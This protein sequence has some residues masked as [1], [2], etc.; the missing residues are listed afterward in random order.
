MA[1]VLA[2]ITPLV[3]DRLWRNRH[4][5]RLAHQLPEML[6]QWAMALQGGLSAEGALREVAR[7]RDD[8]IGREVRRVLLARG[9]RLGTLSSC[10][11]SRSESL[12]SASLAE[13]GATI[14]AVEKTGAPMAALLESLAEDLSRRGAFRDRI[15]ALAR[16]PL[17]QLA[18]SYI[19]IAAMIAGMSYLPIWMG[20]FMEGAP[21]LS[22]GHWITLTGSVAISL[23]ITAVI[24]QRDRELG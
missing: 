1:L 19:L 18:S 5:D 3:V 10:W 13:V 7:R 15:R 23:C 8:E 22:P 16:G 4:E 17:K 20:G 9:L 21:A 14:A 12:G 24:L 2:V 11:Q 6:R